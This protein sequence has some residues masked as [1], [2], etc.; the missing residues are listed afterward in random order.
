MASYFRRLL[1]ALMVN[2][3]VLAFIVDNEDNVD[4]GDTGG[5]LYIYCDGR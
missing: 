5:R 4:N 2:D 1:I 3:V